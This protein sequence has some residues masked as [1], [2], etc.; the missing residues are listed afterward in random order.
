MRTGVSW[1][2][3]GAQ[4]EQGACNSVAMQRGGD[5][6]QDTRRERASRRGCGGAIEAV[7]GNSS[8]SSVVTVG[9]DEWLGGEHCEVYLR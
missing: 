7:V 3:S 5:V 1:A 6:E 4:Q 8:G 2:N 9:R